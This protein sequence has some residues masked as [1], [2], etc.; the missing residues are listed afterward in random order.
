[1]SKHTGKHSAVIARPKN[2]L[3]DT[4]KKIHPTHRVLGAL[5]LSPILFLALPQAHAD[6]VSQDAVVTTEDAHSLDNKPYVTQEAITVASAETGDSTDTF[7]NTITTSNTIKAESAP[8]P[9]PKPKP[10]P[11]V[12]KESKPKTEEKKAE[13]AEAPS[14]NKETD[15]KEAEPQGEVKSEPAIPEA[16]KAET[17][18]A[19]NSAPDSDDSSSTRSKIIE[20]AK[21]H[22]GVP[23]KWGGTTPS[24][25]DCSGY[26]QYVYN[27]VGVGI[28]RTSSAQRNAGTE[29]SKD[30]AEIGDL[31]WMPGHIGIYAGDGMMYHA[32]HTGS[33]VR[34]AKI[35]TSSY[36]VLRML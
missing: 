1:M 35:W 22:I 33:T 31:I 28:P 15:E 11:E 23:Y 29:I 20:E 32:P 4:A 24:G 26:T 34:L 13:K 25:F 36:T 9:K 30:E 21:K 7:G 2:S 27:S 12:K 14:E 6:V 18:P 3:S 10:K 16:K 19:E 5:A 8:K 17:Q